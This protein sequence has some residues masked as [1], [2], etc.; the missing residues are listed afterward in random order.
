MGSLNVISC[1]FAGSYQTSV[2]LAYFAC[3]V[4]E[5][6]GT[7]LIQNCVSGGSTNLFESWAFVYSGNGTC[8]RP[9]SSNVNGFAVGRC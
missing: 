4:Y 6:Q 1:Q 3:F 8:T 5:N 9:G 2:D 7:L